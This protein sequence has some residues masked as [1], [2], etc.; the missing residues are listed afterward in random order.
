MAK[1]G[2][3]LR[4]APILVAAAVIGTG[5]GIM[6]SR[7]QTLDEH[8]A[9]EHMAK[10][11]EDLP[12]TRFPAPPTGNKVPTS[13]F[14]QKAVEGL[15]PYPGA[16]PANLLAQPEGVGGEMQV[17]WFETDDTPDQ[18]IYFY[19]KE[20]ASKGIPFASHFYSQ[21]A[22]YVGYM[23]PNGERQHMLLAIKQGQRTVVFPSSSYPRKLLQ[24]MNGALPPEVP[25][26]PGTSS[27]MVFDFD[28]K[29]L[30][31]KSFVA[32]VDGKSVE[33]VVSWYQ[34]NFKSKGWEVGKAGTNSAGETTLE[35][36]YRPQ[37]PS[38]VARNA[39]LTIRR[40][41]ASVTVYLTLSG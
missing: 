40:D 30:A 18:I 23:E 27:N 25:A 15:P 37:Q 17:A 8:M 26:L 13:T 10:M 39:S 12:P 7:Q 38:E 35:A 14:N 16:V 33:E 31:Q 9:L 11:V 2:F 24:S 4:P 29:T 19:E 6:L 5:T 41:K 32:T 1:T 36:T 21:N 3:I 34:E 20:F 28:E 22:G